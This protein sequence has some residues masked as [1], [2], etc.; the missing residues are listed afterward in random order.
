MVG[1]WATFADNL[2]VLAK[3]CVIREQHCD[4]LARVDHTSATE[5][6][7]DVAALASR[8]RGA[9]LHQRDC[10]LGADAERRGRNSLPAK[11]THEPLGAAALPFDD[12]R[13]GAH[14]SRE[15]RRVVDASLTEDDSRGG[16]ELEAHHLYRGISQ[17]PASG[18]TSRY[19]TPR[20]GSAII[21]S[22]VSRHVR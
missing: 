20:R 10:G 15:L 16:R 7:D 13:A 18:K 22:T 5:C 14:A 17:R 21:G 9:L 2:E 19:F 3:R 8:V 6:Q 4:R 11:L 12:K 1:E